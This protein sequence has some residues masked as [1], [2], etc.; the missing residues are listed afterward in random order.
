[1]VPSEA[2][3]L[4]ELYNVVD[5]PTQSRV[6]VEN[7]S[8]LIVLTLFDKDSNRITLTD[9]VRFGNINLLDSNVIEKK[10]INKIGSEILF[11][12]RSIEKIVKL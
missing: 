2:D 6:L 7:H 9:N 1:M 12:T 4:A 10:S 3:S 8:Y 11:K 5:K